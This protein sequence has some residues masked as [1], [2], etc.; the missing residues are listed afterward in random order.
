MP[1]PPLHGPQQSAP[2]PQRPAPPPDDADLREPLVIFLSPKERRLVL[3]TLGRR[4][5]DRRRA[6][7]GLLGLDA[8][9]RS[10]RN[11]RS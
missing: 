9:A 7:L 8:A 4:H 11:R 6:L 1:R 2:R 10:Q 3:Q 5:K